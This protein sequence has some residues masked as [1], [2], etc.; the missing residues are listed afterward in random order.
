MAIPEQ[1]AV[2]AKATPNAAVRR[3]GVY[4]IGDV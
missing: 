1:A 3:Y 4:Q 2:R